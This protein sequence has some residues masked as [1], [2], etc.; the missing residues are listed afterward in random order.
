LHAPQL[1]G[2]DVRSTHFVA[3][4]FGDGATQ[5]D[6]QAKAVP[7]IEQSAVGATQVFPQEPQFACVLR[8]VSQPSSGRVEQCPKPAEQAAA[9]TTQAPELHVTPVAPGLTFGSVVQSWPQVPQFLGSDVRLTQ[10]EPQMLAVGA[11]QLEAHLGPVAD[12][13][14]RAVGAAHVTPHVPQLFESS[15]LVSQ[16]SSARDEQW[17]YPVAQA[18]G[19]T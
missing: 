7:D 16:P 5:L 9:G 13:A 19:G 10:L 1:V 11:T 18:E 14:Q 12:V 4:R 3:H 6:E 8:S 2:S 17:P 15:R